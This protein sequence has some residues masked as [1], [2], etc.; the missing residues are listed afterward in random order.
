MKKVAIVTGGSQGIGKAIAGRL[1][2]DGFKVAVVARTSEKSQA[3]VDEINKKHAK[4]AIAIE[5][6][7]SNRDDVKMAV[8]QTILIFGDLS[9]MVNNAGVSPITPIMEVDEETLD[10]TQRINVNGVVWG[11]QAAA[12]AFEEL[13]HGGKIINASSQA[14]I[15]GNPNMTVYGATKFAVRGITQTTAKELADKNITVNAYAPGTVK[16]PMMESQVQEQSIKTG[17][18]PKEIEKTM[19]EPV[20]LGR[21][22]EPADIAAGVAFLAGPDSD[23]MTGQTLVLDGGMVFH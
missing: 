15:V 16:T 21:L 11:I 12:K 22:A 2:D 9:V 14:G 1:A 4:S 3:V 18:F 8:K 5:A 17:K 23:Y 19:A 6:D 20:A 10:R 7:V 13:G